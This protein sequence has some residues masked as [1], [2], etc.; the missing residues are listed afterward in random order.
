[1]AGRHRRPGQHGICPELRERLRGPQEPAH[2]TSTACTYG[3]PH[4]RGPNLLDVQHRRRDR[5]R[6]PAGIRSGKAAPT[7]SGK[8]SIYDSSIFIADAALHLMTTQPTWASQNPYQ[9]NEEQFNAAIDLLKQQRDDRRAVLG[10]VRRPGRVVRGGRRHVGTTWQYQVN[11]L[12]ADD[13]ADRGVLPDEGS[14]GWSDTWMIAANAAHP[15]CMLHVDGPHDVGRGQRARRRSGSA[16]RRPASRRATTPRRS[17]RATASR[18]TRP[19]RPTSTRSGTGA[20]RRRTAPTT[21]R[22]RPARPRTTGSR[23]GRRSAAADPRPARP[24]DSRGLPGR[25]SG[26]PS[27]PVTPDR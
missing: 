7:T 2:N 5:R 13:A 23:R 12:Q 26:E 17:R 25:C 3:V 11:L 10:H 6:R 20:R 1:M 9:L 15:N 16:R 8:I 19:T 22:P 4:G 14:T 27:L 24:A 18:R 21:T